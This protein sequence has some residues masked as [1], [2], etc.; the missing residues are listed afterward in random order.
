MLFWH[1]GNYIYPCI[2]RHEIC[3][4][5]LALPSSCPL[6]RF[7]ADDIQVGGTRSWAHPWGNVDLNLTRTF[8]LW[9]LNETNG[10]VSGGCRQGIWVCCHI[11]SSMLD[12]HLA[13]NCPGRSS[14]LYMIS[15]NCSKWCVYTHTIVQNSTYIPYK[16][17]ICSQY[18]P[19]TQINVD[20]N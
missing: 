17:G 9:D 14:L 13:K 2:T 19:N 16:Y 7:W 6:S 20:Y 11:E 12:K 15:T 3:I 4:S 8:A 10:P 5:V 18:E 1:W